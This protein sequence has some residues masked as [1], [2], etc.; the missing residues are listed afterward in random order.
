QSR[1]MRTPTFIF[2]ANLAVSDVVL[3]VLG[4]PFTPLSGLLNS[5]VFGDVLCHLVPT[6]LCLCVHVS[7]QTS[8]AIALERFMV[9]V[10]PF[11]RRMTLAVCIITIFTIWIFSAVLSSPFAFN[12]INYWDEMKFIHD[13]REDWSDVRLKRTFTLL[14]FCLQYILPC[15]IIAFCYS[16]VTISLNE[17]AKVAAR[18]CS[19]AQANNQRN[20]IQRKR[21]TNKMLI[22]MVIFFVLCW[23]PLN[24]L[25]IVWEFYAAVEEKSFFI[26]LFFA[27]HLLAVS[28]T[29]YNPFLYAWMN[30]KFRKEF[31]KIIP[32]YQ[33][34]VIAFKNYKL[35][36][37]KEVSST[38]VNNMEPFSFNNSI[39]N[40][41]Y[42]KEIT[43]QRWKMTTKKSAV[44]HI[45]VGQED[46]NMQNENTLYIPLLPLQP[47]QPTTLSKN[48]L[49]PPAQPLQ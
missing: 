26:P 37:N 24:I 16:K 6:V 46:G 47:Y 12:Q 20:K 10:Y 31:Q 25:L 48:F 44:P 29:V 1:E 34:F 7:T 49:E 27:T 45:E 13:C 41:N 28:S 21:R 4:A 3:C 15:S 8:T 14:T 39:M 38:N 42:N 33:K 5:W 11:K 22:M 30:E 23:M 2:I 35:K 43:E 18:R 17:R 9:I 36:N 40:S 19:F 32:C